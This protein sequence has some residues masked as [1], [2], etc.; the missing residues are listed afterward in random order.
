MATRIVA[1]VDLMGSW[2]RRYVH[3]RSHSRVID[4]E[5]TFVESY[6]Y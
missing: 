3:V 6:V 5:T 2:D 4:V 1:V